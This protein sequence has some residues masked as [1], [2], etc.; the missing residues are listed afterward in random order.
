M[1]SLPLLC[2]SWCN[3]W[4]FTCHMV[5]QQRV[6]GIVKF[7]TTASSQIVHAVCQWKN[8][9]DRLTFGA[10]MDNSLVANF[11]WLTVYNFFIKTLN[12][13]KSVS[14]S[15]KVNFSTGKD[16]FEANRGCYVRSQQTACGFYRFW[17]VKSAKS[18]IWWQRENF[19]KQKWKQMTKKSVVCLKT[20]I[21]LWTFLS[22]R[23]AVDRHHHLNHVLTESSTFIHSILPSITMTLY[24]TFLHHQKII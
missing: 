7:L 12:Q 11:L 8:F 16:V 3:F 19:N 23:S 4:K 10:G 13:N 18:L 22:H 21:P 24:I 14:Q 15:V 1:L 5:V 2:F 9:R 20:A 17:T 6:L